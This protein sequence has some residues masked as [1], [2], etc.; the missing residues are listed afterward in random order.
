MSDQ[1]LSRRELRERER[2]A[3][4]HNQ[5]KDGSLTAEP[6]MQLS[7]AIEAVV[8]EIGVSDSS[9]E[10]KDLSA[11]IPPAIV[12]RQFETDSM[13]IVLPSIPQDIT[14]Q[15]LV[16]KDSQVTIHTGAID[17]PKLD[18][19]EIRIIEDAIVAQAA[20][21]AE[22]QSVASQNQI[23]P[24]PAKFIADSREKVFPSSLKRGRVQLHLVLATA[25]IMVVS[26]GV[27]LAAFMLGLF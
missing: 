16:V 6:R 3:A 27:L 25:L 22:A 12:D 1:P 26:G 10:L 4:A 2:L 5:T 20:M 14:N 23:S 11:S 15:I 8:Q 24:L 9:R 7:E 17:L 18:T 13:S 19:G 21:E